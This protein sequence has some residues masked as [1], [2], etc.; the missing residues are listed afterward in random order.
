M[1]KCKS[2]KIW[3]NLPPKPGVYLFKNIRGSVLY[4]GKAINLKKRIKSYFLIKPEEVRIANL[5]KEIQKVDYISTGSEIETLILEAKLIKEYQPKFNVRL[6]DDK[7]YLYI[8]ITKEDYP[9]VYLIRQPEKESDLLDW[10][11]PFP[12]SESVKEVLR[13][14]RRVFPYRSCK[15]IPLSFCLYYHLELCPGVCKLPI[16]QK[17]HLRTIKK[18]RIFFNG[19]IDLLIRQL[20]KEMNALSKD[21]KFEEA[22]IRLQQIKKIKSILGKFKKIPEE[23][24]IET[25][26]RWLRRVLIRYQGIDPLVIHRLESFDVS[27]LGKDI[28]VGSMTVFTNGEPEN[29]Q[30]RQFKIKVRYGGDPWALKEILLRRLKHKEWFLPQVILV[31]GGKTQLSAALEALLSSNLAGQICLIGLTKEKETLV[32]PVIDDKKIV[33]WKQIP[34]NTRNIGLPLLQFAR[35]EAHR[36]AQRYYRK[37]LRL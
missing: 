32:I 27:N 18:I 20:E 35:D 7:R 21:L 30:Y 3:E 14:I 12:S 2:K 4:I 6:K 16:S 33:G 17:E 24:I 8:G 23:N 25:Q 28:V 5:L 1:K 10:F 15:K 29:S 11:G 31:D 34:K 9:R 37:L 19:K 13:L 22:E 26:L 36:F